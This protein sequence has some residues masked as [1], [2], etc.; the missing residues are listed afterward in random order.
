[1]GRWIES[2]A[3][4]LK[5]LR[6]KL[7]DVINVCPQF[8]EIVGDRR[9]LRFLRSFQGD[10]EK[11]AKGYR[12]FLNWRKTH[13]VDAIREAIVHGGLNT[14][15]KFP[16]GDIIIEI[17]PQIIVSSTALDRKGRPL[18]VETFDFQP[19]EL[20]RHITIDDYLIFLIHALEY[21]TIII[22]Q[23]SHECEMQYLNENPDESKRK[24]GYGVILMDYTIRDFKGITFAHMGQDGRS[25][26]KAALDIGL[27][28]YPEYLGKC[29]MINVPW[30]FNAMWFFIKGLLDEFTLAKISLTGSSYM[31]ELQEDISI[32]NIPEILG[33]KNK[34]YNEPYI[35]DISVGGPLYCPT[36]NNNIPYTSSILSG[37]SLKINDNNDK[38]STYSTI[39]TNTSVKEIENISVIEE[40]AIVNSASS[41]PKKSR[42]MFAVMETFDFISDIESA[43]IHKPIVESAVNNIN[44]NDYCVKCYDMQKQLEIA[45]SS[46]IRTESTIQSIVDYLNSKLQLLKLI[47]NHR[48][49]VINYDDELIENIKYVVDTI[50]DLG[51]RMD[52]SKSIT[53]VNQNNIYND[54]ELNN[55]DIF[56]KWIEHDE[57]FPPPPYALESTE[58]AHLLT[59]WTKDTSKI[60]FLVSWIKHLEKDNEA[61]STEPDATFP[62]GIQITN[63]SRVVKDGFLNFLIPIMRSISDYPLSVKIKEH[64][65]TLATS[66]S[67]NNHNNISRNRNNKDE[68]NLM[69]RSSDPFIDMEETVFDIRI[70]IKQ[71]KFKEF[72][73]NNN[74]ININKHN[75]IQVPTSPLSSQWNTMNAPG[76]VHQYQ[77]QYRTDS[78]DYSQLAE[79]S[80]IFSSP[81]INQIEQRQ[82]LPSIDENRPSGN[83]NIVNNNSVNNNNILLN[84]LSFNASSI[85]SHVTNLTNI[86]TTASKGW[87]YSNN[88]DISLMNDKLIDEL[89]ECEID[90]ISGVADSNN[91]NNNSDKNNNSYNNN[92]NNNYNNYNNN[93]DFDVDS[94]DKNTNKLRLNDDLTMD[95]SIANDRNNRNSNDDTNNKN[96]A[97]PV[98]KIAKRLE[99]M[100]KKTPQ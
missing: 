36:D 20:L 82:R 44:T 97:T 12:D 99:Q 71:N 67:F 59:T 14:P 54:N 46:I 23:M 64:F 72:P 70:K 91:N 90:Q 73:H 96:S 60:S 18:C 41:P 62:A 30:I 86:A 47:E 49:E 28:N 6:E 75:D 15:L 5:E 100:R 79:I 10:V 11:S 52:S 7:S 65:I 45:N 81:G 42:S 92:S 58:V 76:G 37:S 56:D 3:K 43:F 61:I 77:Y 33:G 17:A 69:S 39:T 98:D 21:R 51:S 63:I 2:E 84:P 94:N 53:L 83:Y 31:A 24:D 29:S 88:N 13:N 87:F 25:I 48:I 4:S 89:A 22:E 66:D 40:K 35:F 26:V 1:M 19:A 50:F 9:L 80:T 16:K 55:T 27:P 38:T 78:S 74:Q 34:S 93:N 8:P 68:N 32:E 95:E 57:L 85:I